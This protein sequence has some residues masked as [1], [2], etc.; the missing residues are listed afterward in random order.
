[1]LTH[2]GA[3][4][5]GVSQLEKRVAYIDAPTD[6]RAATLVA[7][8]DAD[9]VVVGGGNSVTRSLVTE[10]MRLAHGLTAVVLDDNLSDADATTLILSGRTDAVASRELLDARV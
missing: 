9:V 1:V 8:P 3:L 5:D 4:A 7:P 10:R 2:D 6:E